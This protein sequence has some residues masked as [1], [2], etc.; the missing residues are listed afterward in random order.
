VCH[1]GT[2][3]KNDGGWL[4]EDIDNNTKKERKKNK[5]WIVER[6]VDIDVKKTREQMIT[7]D[8]SYYIDV[9]K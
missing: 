3:K 9:V 7:Q 4:R 5:E 2:R 8:E 6:R 1:I